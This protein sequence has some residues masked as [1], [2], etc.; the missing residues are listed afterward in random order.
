[1]IENTMI[2]N[3]MQAGRNAL[4]A[5][6][7]DTADVYRVDE[8]SGTIGFQLLHSGIPCHLSL[9]TKPVLIQGEQLAQA[10]SQYTLYC[11]PETD[12][13]EGD[14]LKVT[15]KGETAAYDVGAVFTYDLN[16]LCRCTKR[17]VL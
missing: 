6:Y 8:E 14:R 3:A 5:L 11:A 10:Q 4:Q 17:G 16:K 13:Q 7:T 9:N 1:M 2:E 15:H 12:I